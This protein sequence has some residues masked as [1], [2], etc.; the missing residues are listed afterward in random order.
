MILKEE[1][2]GNTW[3]EALQW[4]NP[5]PYVAIRDSTLVVRSAADTDFW[6]QTHYGFSADSGHFLSLSADADF[7]CTTEVRFRPVNQYDQAGLMIRVS[8]SCW[9]KTSVEYEPTGP[10]RLGVVVTNSGYSDWS[11]QDVDPHLDRIYLRIDRCGPEYT[12]FY[13]SADA[14]DWSQIRMARL[15]ADRK[16][17]IVRAGLYICSPKGEGFEAAFSHLYVRDRVLIP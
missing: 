1:F 15:L 14:S 11:T 9:L 2:D 4:L 8:E 16:N 13:R 6:Q 3:D 7:E 17:G 12:V 5:P 10:A